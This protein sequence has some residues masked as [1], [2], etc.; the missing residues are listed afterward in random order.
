MGHVTPT[1][2]L[3]R[4]I[5]C[6]MLGLDIAYWCTKFGHSNFS[7]SRDMVGTHQD[8]NGSR[9]L[10]T[11]LSGMLCHPWASTYYYQPAY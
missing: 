4:V 6:C 2:P 11:P 7:H 1:M 5:V 10:T 3:L 8:L 9:D